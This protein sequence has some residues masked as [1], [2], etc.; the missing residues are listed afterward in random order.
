MIIKAAAVRT[1]M[2][3][4]STCKNLCYSI[5]RLSISRDSPRKKRKMELLQHSSKIITRYHENA[6]ENMTF[7]FIKYVQEN[8]PCMYINEHLCKE[9]VLGKSI[10]MFI[11]QRKI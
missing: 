10:L 3:S 4:T 11:H 5:K 8:V 2:T 6:G 9:Y 7:Y 1:A